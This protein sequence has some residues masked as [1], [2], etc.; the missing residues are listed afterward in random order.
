MSDEEILER[1]QNL[2][3]DQIAHTHLNEKKIKNLLKR[4]RG[5]NN[6]DSG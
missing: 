1:I 4:Y 3:E 6:G 5:L 2:P